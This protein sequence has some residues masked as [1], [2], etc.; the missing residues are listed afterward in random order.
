M[1]MSR[2]ATTDSFPSM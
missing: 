1:Q 2:G